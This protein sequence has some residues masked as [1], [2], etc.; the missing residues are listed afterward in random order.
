MNM[1]IGALVLALGLVQIGGMAVAE[2]QRNIW[3]PINKMCWINNGTIIPGVA[4]AGEYKV[5]HGPYTANCATGY[6]KFFVRDGSGSMSPVVVEKL[7][8][9]AWVPFKSNVFD[10]Y[11]Q[12]GAGT[13]RIVINNKGNPKPIHYKGSFSI[14]L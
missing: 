12:Y 14:P 5:V 4:Q 10:P 11:E 3:T 8:G 7:Q 9:G 13:F 1:K 6:H 2:P